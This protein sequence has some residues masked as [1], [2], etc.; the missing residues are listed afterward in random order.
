MTIKKPKDFKYV[1]FNSESEFSEYIL[2]NRNLGVIRYWKNNNPPYYIVVI[3]T[4][5][6]NDS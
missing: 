4:G 1:S 5:G 3:Y 2:K 6:E